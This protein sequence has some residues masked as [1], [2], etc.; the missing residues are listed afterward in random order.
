MCY[1]TGVLEAN[2]RLKRGKRVEGRKMET[3]SMDN[4]FKRVWVKWIEIGD[5]NICLF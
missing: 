5:P 4:T 2:G 1:Y 3:V